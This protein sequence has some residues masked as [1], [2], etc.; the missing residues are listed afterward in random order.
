MKKGLII[1]AFVL[2]LMDF[3]VSVRNVN[4]KKNYLKDKEI[5]GVYINNE[6]SEKIPLKGE[7]KFYKAICDDE[8][9]SV[10]WDSESWGLLLKNLTK[11]AKCNLYFYSGQTVFNFDYTGSEQTF[12][13]PV[14]GTYRLETW[15]AQGGVFFEQNASFGGYSIG[16][17]KLNKNEIVYLNVGGK[18]E[19]DAINDPNNTF[20]C[21]DLNLGGYNGGGN[22]TK[23]CNGSGNLVGGGGG[24]GATHIAIIS[25]LLSILENS[26]DKILIVS[27]GGGGSA[28]N[29]YSESG[30]KNLLGG[31][32]GGFTGNLQPVAIGTYYNNQGKKASQDIGYKFGQGADTVL[33]QTNAGGGGGFYGGYADDILNGAGWIPG[34]GGSGYIGNHLLTNKA[35]YC[36]NCEESNEESTKTISTTC[37]EET[38]TNNCAKKGNG[39]ARITLVSID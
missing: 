14:S 4:L 6:L 21:V 19:N 35:M 30:E 36:Y 17:I 3:I 12:V 34:T 5:I 10:S 23:G 20:K 22:G 15:G 8:N 7:A 24:G 29:T 26:K 37:S 25:G 27:G 33:D 9:V 11:K 39:Y 32:G 1:I 31:S 16:H 28:Y 13:A 2:C 18:G 38:P